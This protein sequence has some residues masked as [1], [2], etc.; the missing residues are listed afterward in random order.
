[1]V[2]WFDVPSYY[3]NLRLSNLGFNN[4][5]GTFTVSGYIKV[6]TSTADCYLNLC[7]YNPAGGGNVPITTSYTYFTRTYE[8]VQDHISTAD[9]NGFLDFEGLTVGV[10]IYLKDFKIERGNKATTYTPAPEDVDA[11]ISSAQSTAI[12]QAATNA[13]LLYVTQRCCL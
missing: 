2:F 8:N 4:I 9:Y 1:M 10:R 3:I 13:S 7:D 5:G 11:N 6:S 12:S